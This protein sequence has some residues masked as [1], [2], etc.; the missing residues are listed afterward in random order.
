MPTTRDYYGKQSEGLTKLITVIGTVIGT[1][2]AIGAVFGAL[3]TMYA[4]V[5]GA[6]AKSPR[7]ARSASA[8]CR[9]WSR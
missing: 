4:T 2:M 6:R 9:W 5:A 1:I 8:A 7:C 3:N